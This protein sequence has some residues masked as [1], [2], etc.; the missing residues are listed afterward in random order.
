[1]KEQYR[2]AL[3]RPLATIA[4]AV[5]QMVKKFKTV[6]EAL[7][8]LYLAIRNAILTIA[9]EVEDFFEWIKDM[10]WMC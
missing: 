10:L 1:M 6:L 2:I 3:L 9:D 7:M 4:S 5:E 8:D